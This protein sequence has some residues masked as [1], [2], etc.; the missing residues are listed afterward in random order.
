MNI[1]YILVCAGIYIVH[2][3]GIKSKGYLACNYS[4]LY[5][6]EKAVFNDYCSYNCK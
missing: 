4:Q 6:I 1:Q 5:G 2:S 3:V